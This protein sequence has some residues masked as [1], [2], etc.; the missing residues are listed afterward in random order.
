MKED[1]GSKRTSINP[2]LISVAEAAVYFSVSHWTIRDLIASG[3]LPAVRIGRRLLLKKEDV[4]Q[5][6]EARTERAERW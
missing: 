3:E 2:R 4:D 5:F 6:I 1:T